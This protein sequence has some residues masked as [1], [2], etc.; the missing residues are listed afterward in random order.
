MVG[1]LLICSDIQ[2]PF[3]INF[4]KYQRSSL[5]WKLHVFHSQF[6]LQPGISNL[7][8]GH[9]V[10]GP[11]LGRVETRKFISC[12]KNSRQGP[13]YD[14]NHRPL[15]LQ[16]NAPRKE[17]S[18]SDT[19]TITVGAVTR[20]RTWAVTATTRSINHYH[21][22]QSPV[23]SLFRLHGCAGWSGSIQ[24]KI[25]NSLRFQQGKG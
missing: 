18:S 1:P 7:P 23:Q 11:Q 8:R 5:P 10:R 13:V 20:I 14:S 15:D 4:A 16:S 24:T 19:A 21:V 9:P 6:C 3:G 2:P 22:G 25:L 17:L 12:T